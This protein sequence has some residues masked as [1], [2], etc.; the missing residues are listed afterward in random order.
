MNP[1]HPPPPDGLHDGGAALWSDVVAHFDLAL[2]ELHAL[3]AA[4]RTVDELDRLHAALDES[5]TVVVGSA[6]QQQPNK[7][8]AEVRAHRAALAKHLADAG[9]PL[10]EE[11][12]EDS[13]ATRRARQAAEARWRRESLKKA[14]RDG[15]A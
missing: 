3:A 5:P 6:G 8:F 10:D 1:P 2:P 13:P 12:V 4:C 7:L 9:L 15:A 11:P 14:R